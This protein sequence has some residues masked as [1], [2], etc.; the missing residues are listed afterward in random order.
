MS[1]S[2]AAGGAPPYPPLWYRLAGYAALPLAAAYLLWR[3][4]RQRAYRRH[5]AERFLGRGGR[6]VP[7]VAPLDAAGPVIWVH[8]VSV[9]E[10]RA[11]QPLVAQLAQ[12]QPGAR[13]VLTHMTPTGREA[14]A[15]LL[16]QLPGRITQRYLPY[17]TALAVGRF[18]DEVR[19]QVGVLMETEIWPTL[20]HAARRRGIAVVLAN[21]RLS[22]RS[23]QKALRQPRLM[24]GAAATLAA[25]GAQSAADAQRIA[26]LYDGPVVVTGNAK[27]DQQPDA[28]LLEQGRRWRARLDARGG[29]RPLW[30]FASSRDGEERLLLQ[31]LAAQPAPAAR[32][33]VVP[34]HPQR[35]DDVASLLGERGDTVVRRSQWDT[36]LAGPETPREVLLGDSMGEMALYYAMADIAL[37]GGSLLPLG[38]QNLIEA[39]ACG[40]AVVLGPHM[41]NFAV[42]AADAVAAGAA[43]RARDADEA[44]QLV[45]QLCA[46]PQR[47]AAMAQ[48]GRAFAAAHRGATQRTVALVLN[49]LT[50]GP[51]TAGAGGGTPSPSGRGPG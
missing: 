28:A 35:F 48:A 17:D 51:S 33:L 36:A 37:I 27:F 21:A 38:G 18:L 23:L 44:V 20:L 26:R 25:V 19:P 4:R 34:R 16:R 50:P 11:A 7:A 39:C 14:G 42:A 40:C 31:A 22:G 30:L 8:A 46:E 2:P 12:A 49:A 3:S 6:A 15:D 29:A 41:F 45:A 10:T 47:R 43:L 5:W 1:R 13:F 24:R 32:L 9:G